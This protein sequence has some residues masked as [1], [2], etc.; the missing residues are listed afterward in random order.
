MCDSR[1]GYH[2]LMCLLGSVSLLLLQLMSTDR[3]WGFPGMVPN[4]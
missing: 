3:H 1:F 4:P 2:L